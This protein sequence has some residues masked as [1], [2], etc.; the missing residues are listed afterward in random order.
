MEPEGRRNEWLD[1]ARA[2]MELEAEAI[3]AAARRLDGNLSRAVDLM[4]AHSG[5]VVV[6][7]I[8]KSGHVGKKIVATLCSTG[9]PAV[10]LHPAEATHGDLGVYTHGDPTLM[11]SKNGTTAELVRLV[12]ILRKLRSPLIGIVGNPASPLAR[13]MDALLDATVE[14]EA[15][16]NNL[17]PT[18]SVIVALSL[19]HALA[20]A[21]MLA[22]NFS[23]EEFGRLHPGGQLGRNL[24]LS[25]RDAMHRGEE[26]A[27]ASPEDSLKEVVI[28]MTQRPLGAA[29]IVDE[30][31]KLS[32]LITDGDL[33]RALR[34]HDDIRPLRA[35]DVMTARPIVVGPDARLL[36][37]L[38]LMEDRPSEIS[39]LPV[40]DPASGRCLG[41]I[42]LHDLYQASLG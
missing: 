21:L 18:A 13:Q 8:G 38:R 32:G 26:V 42:R 35:A 22:R 11:I 20:V 23:V 4:L 14:R 10:F 34:A 9:T 29:C 28:L 2:A 5:K 6:T 40:T 25:V 19:G 7:G 39:V 27:W 41:L 37:A 24:R 31:G 12:P 33:R 1:A 30:N 15:D 16:P 17:A 36:E 3:T